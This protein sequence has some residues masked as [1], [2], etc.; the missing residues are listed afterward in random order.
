[1]TWVPRVIMG[2]IRSRA[3][4]YEQISNY[5]N[6]DMCRGGTGQPADEHIR[7][8]RAAGREYE[9]TE[10]GEFDNDVDRAAAVTRK[11]GNRKSQIENL[12]G[13]QQDSKLGPRDMSPLLYR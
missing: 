13:A 1:M 6:V 7:I 2:S 12:P 11:T 5:I 4:I 9:C 10:N 8:I 3:K